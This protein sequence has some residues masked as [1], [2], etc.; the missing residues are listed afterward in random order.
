MGEER[1][2]GGFGV[3]LAGENFGFVETGELRPY[4]GGRVRSEVLV[5]EKPLA[6]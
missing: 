3:G 1:P 5:L 4:E 2:G 6:P